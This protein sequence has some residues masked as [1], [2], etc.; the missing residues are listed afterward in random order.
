MIAKVNRLFL[1]RRKSFSAS[2]G[3]DVESA[4]ALAVLWKRERRTPV[5]RTRYYKTHGH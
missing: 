2:R 5:R 4:A 1:E 3:L